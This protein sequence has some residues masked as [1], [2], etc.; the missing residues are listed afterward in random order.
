MFSCH[1]PGTLKTSYTTETKPLLRTDLIST[2]A[3][4]LG[5]IRMQISGREEIASSP[6]SPESY[7]LFLHVTCSKPA[8]PQKQS[9]C[10]VLT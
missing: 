3:L 10:C 7:A 2:L 4:T 5:W 1:T 6:T 9:R 8:T